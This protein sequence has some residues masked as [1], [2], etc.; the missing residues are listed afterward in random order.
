MHVCIKKAKKSSYRKYSKINVIMFYFL[1][2]FT[3]KGRS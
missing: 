2:L 1:W 3:E